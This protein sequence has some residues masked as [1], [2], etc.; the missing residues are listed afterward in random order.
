MPSAAKRLLQVGVLSSIASKPLS[1]PT[2]A[3]AVA[4][5][6]CAFMLDSP[7]FQTW[8]AYGFEQLR[9]VPR[10]MRR[11]QRVGFLRSPA[12]API[13]DHRRML[14]QHRIDGGPRRLDRVLAREQRAVAV[15]RVAEQAFIWRL[16]VRMFLDQAKLVL[17]ADKVLAVA[18]H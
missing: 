11:D 12:A 15:H 6:S 9:V 18:F 13:G 2:M 10:T 4:I 17:V 3:A 7:L 16:L 14:A 8:F 1:V 5:N